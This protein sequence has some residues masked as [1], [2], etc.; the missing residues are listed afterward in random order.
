MTPIPDRFEVTKQAEFKE[1]APNVVS[2][3]NS[4]PSDI[5]FTITSTRRSIGNTENKSG[6]HPVG[7]AIDLRDNEESLKFW[8]W[9][10][11]KDGSKWKS[12]NNVSILKE[13]DHYHV[14]FN[15][16]NK[17]ETTVNKVEVQK[18]KEV[19]PKK[20]E[21]KK[22]ESTV[23][24]I[25]LPIV[26]NVDRGKIKPTN[27]TVVNTENNV[28]TK[29]VE[30]STSAYI[31][32]PV[33][34]TEVKPEVKNVETEKPK[35]LVKDAP[36]VNTKLPTLKKDLKETPQVIINEPSVLNKISS[37]VSDIGSS[38]AET[39]SDLNSQFDRALVKYTPFGDAAEQTSVVKNN[40]IK[41]GVEEKQLPK[42]GVV[43]GA[44]VEEIIKPMYKKLGKTPQGYVS[45]INVF[46]NRKGF[47]Y[48]PTSK[49][50]EKKEYSAKHIAHFLYDFDINSETPASGSEAERLFKSKSKKEFK[51]NNPGSTV[52]DP[53][54]TVYKKNANGTVNVKYK[55]ASELTEQD[56]VADPLRQYKYSDIEWE[57]SG[58]KALG[59]N[60]SVKALYTK[61]GKQTFFIFPKGVK[62]AYGKFGGNSVVY[63]ING[64]NVAIDFAGS[65]NQIN[66]QAKQI[67]KDYKIN[68]EDLII[69]YH[70]VGSY[71]AKPDAVNGKIKSS[72]YDQFNTN[73]E[74]GAG[75]AIPN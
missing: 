26:K 2:A 37:A 4:L 8:N 24:K 59:F 58:G 44:K 27:T 54:F 63:L 20:E 56:K 31:P 13:D 75:L 16:G 53:Y 48:V 29:T 12:D 71:S 35:A 72:Q 46:D 34:K 21:I 22:S 6:T 33:V 40:T 68:P 62:D 28:E 5:N 41:I 1:A 3:L 32:K 66:T 50:G 73:S 51:A 70:D 74:T 17:K 52:T 14:E 55:K 60:N 64:K 57:G 67:I 30:N 19:E 42:T 10:D 36:K 69:S 11:T 7:Q 45:Y 65:V 38:I 49:I 9:L 25:S 15:H 39:V 61:N 18:P 43:A 47:D 23:R